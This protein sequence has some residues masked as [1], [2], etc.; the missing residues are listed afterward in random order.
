MS[1]VELEANVGQ[2]LC[3]SRGHETAWGDV[4]EHLEWPVQDVKS[5]RAEEM[6]HTR[7]RVFKVVMARRQQV[8]SG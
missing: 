6:G 1:L 4:N 2:I 5:A 8:P 7:E 3:D